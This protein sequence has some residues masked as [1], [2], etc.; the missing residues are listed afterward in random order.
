MKDDNKLD[1]K[2]LVSDNWIEPPR[3][4][5]KRKYVHKTD[6]VL[7]QLYIFYVPDLYLPSYTVIQIRIISSK[8]CAKV[9]QQNPKNHESL[10][11]LSCMSFLIP[12]GLFLFA[13]FTHKILLT[14]AVLLFRHDFQFFNTQ[15]LS[16]LYEK[17]VR[18]LMVCAN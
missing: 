16:E 6:L 2:K 7:W 1:F 11:C 8:L 4:E 3:R 9:V 12:L 14:C 13:H 15:R 10:A 5:R 17:E 18:Y